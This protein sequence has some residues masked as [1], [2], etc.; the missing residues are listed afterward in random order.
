M[1]RI[2]I[3]SKNKKI[4]NKVRVTT[5]GQILEQEQYRI[6]INKEANRQL[7]EFVSS[8]NTGFEGGKVT[9]VD[10]ANYVFSRLKALLSESDIKS[11]Q[12][13]CFNEKDALASLTKSEKDL[14]DIV[15]KALREAY[16]LLDSHKKRVPK[17]SPELSTD[18]SVDNSEAS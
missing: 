16:G 17:S 14:P 2:D 7:E 3:E 1:E 12:I 8:I 5:D 15:K 10:V 18:H 4:K 9:R 13:S 6:V 11:I